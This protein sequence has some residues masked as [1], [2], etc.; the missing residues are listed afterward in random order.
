VA[1]GLPSISAIRV[2]AAGLP[3]KWSDAYDALVKAGRRPQK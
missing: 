1:A 3:K 2:R